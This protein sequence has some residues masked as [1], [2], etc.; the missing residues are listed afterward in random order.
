M[1][2]EVA[3]A[4][5][6]AGHEWTKPGSMLKSTSWATENAMAMMAGG[7]AAEENKVELS[8]RMPSGF[9]KDVEPAP[10][11]VA[12]IERSQYKAAWR[13]TDLVDWLRF[14]A[15]LGIRYV[16]DNAEGFR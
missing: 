1:N 12:D 2:P 14:Q 9:P 3:D 13:R 4:L 5:L 8:V 7:P 6:A 16:R 10:Q 11:S 15:Q